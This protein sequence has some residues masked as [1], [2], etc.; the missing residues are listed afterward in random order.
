[1]RGRCFRLTR[2]LFLFSL[3][4][5]AGCATTTDG[6][7]TRPW[8]SADTLFHDNPRWLGADAAYSV[9]LDGN[10][11]LWLFGDTFIGDGASRRR[12]DAQFI[13]N[14]IAIQTGLDVR[15]ADMSFHW[16]GTDESPDSFFP[17]T[18]GAWLWP[19]HGLYREGSLT[20]FFMRV[21]AKRGGLGF[22]LAGAAALRTDDISGPPASWKFS[23]FQL[24]DRPQNLDL[25]FGVAVL[26]DGGFVYA[27]CA[28]EGGGHPVYLVRWTKRDF[29][30]GR[31]PAAQ[32]WDGN[33]WAYATLLQGG[34][35]VVFHPG[36]TEFSV[37]HLDDGRFI[38]V[39]SKG[40][41]QSDIALRTAPRPEGPWSRIQAVYRPRESEREGTLVYAAKAHPELGDAP[42]LVTYAAN[43]FD[44]ETLLADESLYYP[45]FVRIRPRK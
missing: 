31:L 5:G 2:V 42:I 15:T 30:Q 11:V 17:A 45:R 27:F 14:S 22:A 18:E 23:A 34:P 4:A 13:R 20:L 35:A 12:T 37:H 9:P 33:G 44:P 8:R 25:I 7:K 16:G 26:E 19:V 29:D 40:F 32:W 6:W 39:Q 28:Q 1:M 10:R 3:L 38:Q 43:H 36:A 21:V 41:P 24:P